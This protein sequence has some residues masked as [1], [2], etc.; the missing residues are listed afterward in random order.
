MRPAEP[1]TLPRTACDLEAAELRLVEGTSIGA[2]QLDGDD[3]KWAPVPAPA[4]MRMNLAHPAPALV[5]VLTCAKGQGV[6][7]R[8]QARLRASRSSP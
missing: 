8:L 1:V 7:T 6:A 2:Y 5:S 3:W 4:P